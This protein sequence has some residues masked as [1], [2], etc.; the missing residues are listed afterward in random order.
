[1]HAQIDEGLHLWPKGSCLRL[2][3]L[4][5]CHLRR[6][7]PICIRCQHTVWGCLI[8]GFQGVLHLVNNLQHIHF[9]P[10]VYLLHAGRKFLGYAKL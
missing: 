7:E 10:V 8:G 5:W 2:R 9:C 4:H 1:M 6:H 3:L